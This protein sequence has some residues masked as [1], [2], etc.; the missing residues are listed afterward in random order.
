M[1]NEM[2]TYTKSHTTGYDEVQLKSVIVPL[3]PSFCAIKQ[4]LYSFQRLFSIHFRRTEVAQLLLICDH[5]IPSRKILIVE[6]NEDCR[7]LQALVI[8]RLGYIVLEADNGVTA[9]EEA[10][11]GHPDL[12]LMDLSM[13]K[14]N[15]ED[16]IVELKNQPSTRDI[17]V[18]ICTAYDPGQ[19]VDR[20]LSA[21]AVE[22]LH[23][24]FKFS[25]LENLLRK[26]ML[27]DEKFVVE[28][29]HPNLPANRTE[30]SQFPF[31]AR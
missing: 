3:M 10:L 25:E 28:D 26:H 7:E 11:A 19:R 15:G 4:Y 31:Q 12:I 8:R 6:D 1:F 27:T 2:I 29:G 9:I 20:A 24:P 5:V 13:P 17:P 23:K 21:G 30:T 22:V 16:A 14:M 18:I